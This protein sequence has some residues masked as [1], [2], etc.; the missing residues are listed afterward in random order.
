M[1]CIQSEVFRVI[2]R[3]RNIMMSGKANT[4]QYGRNKLALLRATVR[5]VEAIVRKF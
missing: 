2:I 4:H 3:G 5:E 1:P